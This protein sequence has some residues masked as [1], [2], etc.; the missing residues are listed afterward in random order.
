MNILLIDDHFCAR[1]GVAC[2][3]KQIFP[4]LQVFEAESFDTGLA[5]VRDTPLNLVL[6]DIQLPGKDGLTGLAE[7]RREFPSLCVAMFSGLDDRE[8]VFEALRLGAMGFIVKSVSRQ[9]FVEALRDVLSGRVYLPVSVVGPQAA[10]ETGLPGAAA[11]VRPVSDPAGLGLTPREFEVLG[12]LVQ[13]LCNK[14]IARKL[15]IEEQT[16]K[17]HLRPIFQKFAVVRRTELL[18]K[19][20]EMGIVF[21]RPEVGN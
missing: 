12:W 10:W 4:E 5:I 1:A 9:A 17:N 14:E 6:L 18:V 21:G 16:V 8:L 11:G 13:G 20:F 19:V 15:G 7:L 2:L 3:L